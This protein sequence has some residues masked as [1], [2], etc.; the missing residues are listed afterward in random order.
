MSGDINYQYASEL[1]N[2]IFVCYLQR[3]R[4]RTENYTCE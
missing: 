4:L 2:K 1:E 3:D